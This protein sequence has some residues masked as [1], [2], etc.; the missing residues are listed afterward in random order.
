MKRVFTCS[1]FSL[2][3]TPLL[4][5]PGTAVMTG[6]L[7]LAASRSELRQAVRLGGRG[8]ATAAARGDVTPCAREPGR[9]ALR[10]P[11]RAL[12]SR[13]S[14]NADMASNQHYR[15]TPRALSVGQYARCMHHCGTS[16]SM[17]FNHQNEH[18]SA[19]IN[20]C[21][22]NSATCVQELP[23][24]TCGVCIPHLGGALA[25]LAVVC[26]YLWPTETACMPLSCACVVPLRDVRISR[27]T[28]QHS[29]DTCASTACWFLIPTD[30][31]SS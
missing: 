20:A 6:T 16:A 11:A 15:A 13:R 4:A 25:S 27:S 5:L 21:V 18:R 9:G 26:R 28:H 14:A 2:T 30:H 24:T 29:V 23:C 31:A 12:L 10:V 1:S 3:G 17:H 8:T 22:N 19:C 7:W